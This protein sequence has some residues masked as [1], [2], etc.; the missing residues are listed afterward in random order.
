MV[1]EL[2]LSIVIPLGLDLYMPVPEDNPLTPDKI[3]LGRQLFFDRRLSRDQ[4]IACATCHD[5]A[6]AFS[7]AR[8]RA[9]GVFGREG[10]RNALALVNR[11][12]GRVFFW[13][14]RARS[15]EEQVLNPIQNPN[16]MDLQVAEA[17]ARVGL[18]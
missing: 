4:S 14:A 7:D 5:P 11:G 15:L 1:L 18:S 17:A 12:Y 13:D 6:R 16:E 3:E 10:P 8:P 9:V 2:M